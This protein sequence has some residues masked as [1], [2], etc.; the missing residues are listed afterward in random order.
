MK[1]PC[2]LSKDNKNKNIFDNP[3]SGT[4]GVELNGVGGENSYLALF[5]NVD[6]DD[7]CSDTREKML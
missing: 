4:Y 5:I 6:H 3:S 1:R 2:F 7:G